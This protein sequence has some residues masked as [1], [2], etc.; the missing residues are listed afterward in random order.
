MTACSRGPD[1]SVLTPG[2]TSPPLGSL[3]MWHTTCSC[4]RVMRATSSRIQLWINYGLG[5]RVPGH[6]SRQSPRLVP[7]IEVL[8]RMRRVLS[9]TC[10]VLPY[11]DGARQHG[12]TGANRARQ[13]HL[14]NA[15]CW[16][17]RFLP[18]GSTGPD[19]ALECI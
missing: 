1:R 2:P 17:R 16:T 14:E 19:S 12:S 8:R 3:V 15:T 7:R 6:L 13:N 4:V 10:R 5:T 11:R 9:L 18:L